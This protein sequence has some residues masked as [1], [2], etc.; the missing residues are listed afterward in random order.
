MVLNAA[1]LLNKKRIKE[2]DSIVAYLKTKYAHK[3]LEFDWTGPWPP[4]NFCSMR[5]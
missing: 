2:F 5:T 1:F 4:Y 3:G